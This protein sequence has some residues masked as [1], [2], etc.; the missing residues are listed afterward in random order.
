MSGSDPSCP[1]RSGRPPRVQGTGRWLILGAASLAGSIVLNLAQAGFA[2]A[3]GRPWI[4]AAPEGS[5]VGE[6]YR[7]SQ[8]GTPTPLPEAPE[9]LPGWIAYTRRADDDFVWEVFRARADGSQDQGLTFHALAGKGADA[10]RWSPDGRWLLY[11]TTDKSGQVVTLWRIA[12]QGGTPAPLATV[13]APQAGAAS[14]GPDSSGIAFV[15]AA[16]AGPSTTDLLLRTADATARPLVTTSDREEDMPDWS[17]AS[18]RIA[19]SARSLQG[20][21]VGRGWDLFAVAP[22]GSQESLLRGTEGI[23]ECSARWSPDGRRLAYLAIAGQTCFGAGTVHILDLE[24]G[25]DRP[26]ISGASIQ[27]TWS[28]DGLWLLVYNTYNGGLSLP[29][30]P[31]PPPAARQQLKGLYVFNLADETLYR[32]KGAAGGTAAKEG[33]YLWGQVADWTGGTAAPSPTATVTPEPSETMEAP[34][35]TASPTVGPTLTLSPTP[36][37]PISP[38]ATPSQAVEPSATPLRPKLY[39]P[40]LLRLATPVSVGSRR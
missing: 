1:A 32:L 38:S 5:R 6:R 11:A 18:D 9:S 13:R 31:T 25:A 19:F 20:P 27:A 21:A 28:P 8:D 16:A 22:D 29:G 17:A 39:L 34:S 4:A 35:P 23:S 2:R 37:A 40:L 33:S 3:E 14:V 24:T 7:P 36:E 30:Q 15:A 10:P 26:V 12:A